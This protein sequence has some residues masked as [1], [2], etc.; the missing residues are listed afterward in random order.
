MNEV[1]S[2]HTKFTLEKSLRP[3]SIAASRFVEN[4]PRPSMA[5]SEDV[6]VA[7]IK[8]TEAATVYRTIVGIATSDSKKN[9]ER[10][11][12]SIEINRDHKKS[13]MGDEDS[14]NV[15]CPCVQGSWLVLL[16]PSII[17]R[18]FSPNVSHG[19]WP[20]VYKR[21]MAPKLILKI[22]YYVFVFHGSCPSSSLINEVH[23]VQMQRSDWV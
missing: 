23:I 10:P 20:S 1:K 19:S 18:R 22:Q 9:Y 16:H 13:F 17:L 12:K 2:G 21:R 6:A 7:A 4:M 11:S 8:R 3:P 5:I 14:L 15:G